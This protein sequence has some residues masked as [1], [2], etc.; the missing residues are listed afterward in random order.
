MRE[1]TTIVAVEAVS[2]TYCES[3]CVALGIQHAMPVLLIAI[4]P[5]RLCSK[6]HISHKEHDLKKKKVFEHKTCVL[7]FSTT[8]I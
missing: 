7:N 3:V 5:T 8:F 1:H 2:I 4:R 6:F